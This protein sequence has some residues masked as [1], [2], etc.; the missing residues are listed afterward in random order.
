MTW[1]GAQVSY[2]FYLV[3]EAGQPVNRAGRVV[4]FA[5]AVFV[6]DVYTYSVVWQ[7]LE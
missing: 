6:T 4:P 1:N 3:N 2:V 7:G 5:E